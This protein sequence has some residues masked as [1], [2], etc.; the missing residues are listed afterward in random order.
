MPGVDIHI[1]PETGICSILKDDGK[2]DLMPDEAL[3]IRE[4][5]GNPEKIREVI[6]QCDSTFGAALS[7]AELGQ[8][9]EEVK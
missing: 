1:C 8:I 9:S 4:A 5:A 2:V 6:A 3:A 7:A